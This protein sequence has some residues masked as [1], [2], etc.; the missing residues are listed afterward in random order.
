MIIAYI[1]PGSGVMLFQIMIAA[2]LGGVTIFWQRIRL[3][4]GLKEKS[5]KGSPAE[6]LSGPE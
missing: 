1:D 4:L 6:D 5:Q 3:L 2:I